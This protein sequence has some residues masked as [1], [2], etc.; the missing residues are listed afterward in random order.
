MWREYFC[1]SCGLFYWIEQYHCNKE[2]GMMERTIHLG[3]PNPEC[4]S[5]QKEEVVFCPVD[6]T[7][8]LYFVEENKEFIQQ[9]GW[10]SSRYAPEYAIEVYKQQGIRIVE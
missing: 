10:S 1:M 2:T 6:S 3:C 4:S 8:Y 5:H 9:F 7:M